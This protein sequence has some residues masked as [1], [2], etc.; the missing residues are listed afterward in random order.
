VI[1]RRRFSLQLTPLMDMLLIVMF[2]QYMEAQRYESERAQGMEAQSQ[3][4]AQA[5]EAAAGFEQQR[6][7]LTDQINQSRLENEE[8][9]RQNQSLREDAD[10]FASQHEVLADLLKQ[11]FEIPP[12]ELEALL[13]PNRAPALSE[14]P[15]ELERIRQEFNAMAEQ[16]SGRAVTHLLTYHEILKFCDVWELKVDRNFFTLTAG[17]EVLRRRLPVTADGML[18]DAAAQQE[19]FDVMKSLEAPNELVV[20]LLTFD[21][22][23]LIDTETQIRRLMPDLVAQYRANVP[24]DKQV[25][26]ADFGHGFE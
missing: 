16:S 5:E 25:H 20:I 1:A 14:S 10:R 19:L 15:S 11:L 13:D 7:D 6:S 26:Y 4:L 12:E 22:E 21:R 3:R 17:D 8:L 24:G 18:D 9:A 23:C 2:A